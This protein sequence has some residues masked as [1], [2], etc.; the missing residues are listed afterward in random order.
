MATW[1]EINKPI[2]AGKNNLKPL[3]SMNQ[4]IL[5]LHRQHFQ[6]EEIIKLF[7]LGQSSILLDL[8]ICR[9]RSDFASI[10]Q[11]SKRLKEAGIAQLGEQQTEASCVFWR[12]RV[13]ST[14]LALL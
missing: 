10:A 8:I 11:S 14:V 7:F 9:S 5:Y 6:V 1:A 13:Q 4:H 2:S 12:S 3:Y